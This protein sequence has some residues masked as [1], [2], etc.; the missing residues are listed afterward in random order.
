MTAKLILILI[1]EKHLK[2]IILMPMILVCIK[3]QHSGL[4]GIVLIGPN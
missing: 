1:F 4:W 2:A 3:D